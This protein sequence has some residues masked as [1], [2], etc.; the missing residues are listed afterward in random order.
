M[1]R[2][3]NLSLPLDYTDGDLLAL[4]AR[5]LKIQP[6]RITGMTLVKKSVDA[7][8][9]GDVHFVIAIDLQV[10][11]ENDVLRRLKPGVS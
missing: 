11:D 10:K 8:D 3:N 2:L 5:K 4:A 6:G 7:R 9:K 1:L